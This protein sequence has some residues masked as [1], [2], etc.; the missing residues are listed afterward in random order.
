MQKDYT[1]FRIPNQPEV[2]ASHFDAT[3]KPEPLKIAGV[4]LG[5]VSYQSVEQK[6]PFYDELNRIAEDLEQ[7]RL[8]NS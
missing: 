1:V 6:C 4:T 2:K 7:C 3:P 5:Q 8:R